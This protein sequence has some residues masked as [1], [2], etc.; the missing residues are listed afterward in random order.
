G[1]VKLAVEDDRPLQFTG[2]AKVYEAADAAIVGIRSGEVLPGQVVVV[3]GLGP[4]GTPGMGM[5]TNVVF[6]LDGMGL[7]KQ[8]AV[9][10]DGQQSGLSN[11]VLVVGEVSPEAA[12]GGPL[13]W[14]EDGDFISIDVHQRR[15]DLQ[16]AEDILAERQ[17]R[18][19]KAAAAT[20]AA[21]GWLSIYRRL[22]RPLPEGAVLIES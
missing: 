15:V 10:T 21:H 14:V 8:V 12:E 2:P 18:C 13:A 4:K 9:V 7:S 5:A 3:R 22:V 17:E 16:V 19:R 11:K 6:A 1:I 20:A